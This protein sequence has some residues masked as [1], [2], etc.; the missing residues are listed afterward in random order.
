MVA[1]ERTPGHLLAT[2]APRSGGRSGGGGGHWASRGAHRAVADASAQLFSAL[3][4][5]QFTLAHVP[6]ESAT[7][8]FV[9][10]AM[11]KVQK[12]RRRK[13]MYFN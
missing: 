7:T 4:F 12:R 13:K 2:A 8:F 1:E 6:M 11:E 9:T 5:G 3:D 10:A